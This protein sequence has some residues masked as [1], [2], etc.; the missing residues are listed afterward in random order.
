MICFEQWNFS[1]HGH[2]LIVADHENICD[3]VQS[4]KN[5][6]FVYKYMIWEKSCIQI[7]NSCNFMQQKYEEKKDKSKWSFNFTG[8]SK[9]S[10]ESIFLLRV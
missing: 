8:A 3:G 6:K 9:G 4:P 7:S 10:N 2:D 5:W 1:G